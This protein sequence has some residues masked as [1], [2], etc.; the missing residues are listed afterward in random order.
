MG[1]GMNATIQGAVMDELIRSTVQTGFATVVAAA[2]AVTP[3][4]LR[5]VPQPPPG[6]A[7]GTTLTADAMT[8]T[9]PLGALAQQFLANQVTDCS[10]IC[11]FIVQFATQPLVK[12]AV[13]PV[14]FAQQLRSGQ[15][16]LQATALTDATVSGAANTAL[17]CIM[18]NDLNAALP[19]A[20]HSLETALIGLLRIGTTAATAPADLPQAI[21]TAR[22]EVFAA[23]R[24]PPGPETPAVR[25]AWEAA[26]VRAIEVASAFLFQAPE[27]LL[28]GVTQ[29]ADALF[30]TL[31]ATGSVG[32]ALAAV[33]ASVAA[34]VSETAGFIDHA[35]TRPIPVTPAAAGR[36]AAADPVQR[37]PA[38]AAH[39]PTGVRQPPSVELP[40]SAKPD[41]H[42][43]PSS[44]SRAERTHRPAGHRSRGQH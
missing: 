6:V 20:Q 12:F 27:R 31:G 28:L 14:T 17:T 24:Q 11:P 8:L 30:T 34:T 42:R 19:R 40:V 22:A 39:T 23:L 4:P 33:H 7:A 9:P 43:A 41:V 18:T 21:L 3:V 36:A 35:F 15:P 44:Q 26:S 16:L 1:R 29:A 13:I 38:A 25:N 2:L 37:L 5:S 32:T 10:L